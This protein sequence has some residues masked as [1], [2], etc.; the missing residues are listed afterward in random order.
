[1]SSNLFSILRCHKAQM[2]CVW[3]QSHSESH[4]L[5]YD[6]TSPTAS[7]LHMCCLTLLFQLF[8]ETESILLLEIHAACGQISWTLDSAKQ[9]SHMTLIFH[10]TCCTVCTMLSSLMKICHSLV[11]HKCSHTNSG[12]HYTKIKHVSLISHALQFSK[13]YKCGPVVLNKTSS[14]K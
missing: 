1:M 4:H 12:I 6:N 3:S 13:H 14:R 7:T 9:T 11:H 8:H 5:H 10:K 2:P